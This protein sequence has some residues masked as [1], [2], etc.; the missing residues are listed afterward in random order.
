MLCIV[1]GRCR[2]HGIGDIDDKLI[3]IQQTSPTSYHHITINN[4]YLHQ[5]ITMHSL[6]NLFLQT[7]AVISSPLPETEQLSDL[8]LLGNEM[9]EKDSVRRP[10][11]G[12]IPTKAS[13]KSSLFTSRKCHQRCDFF[14]LTTSFPDVK[15]RVRLTKVKGSK[16]ILS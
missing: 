3:Y 15:F 7:N 5:L 11:S 1:G 9:L 4:N 12:G 8:A 13:S 10:S 14:N 16:P 6:L 2:G